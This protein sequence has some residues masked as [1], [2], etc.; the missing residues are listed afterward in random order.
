LHPNVQL[1]TKVL[2][3]VILGNQIIF[4]S[5]SIYKLSHNCLL[6]IFKCFV[7]FLFTYS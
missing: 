7:H 3:L 5:S 6:R 1:P 2:Q 4:F